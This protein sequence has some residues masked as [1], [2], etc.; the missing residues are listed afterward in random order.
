MR[1][2]ISA[3]F[4]FL[5]EI[6]DQ[7]HINQNKAF[8]EFYVETYFWLF[9]CEVLGVRLNSFGTKNPSMRG[10]SSYARKAVHSFFCMLYRVCPPS[11]VSHCSSVTRIHNPRRLFTA[12]RKFLRVLMHAPSFF[13]PKTNISS[14]SR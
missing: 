14:H 9:I 1:A 13:Q 5:Q 10:I 11:K 4:V 3:S 7:V 8:D 6:N 12:K 2:N